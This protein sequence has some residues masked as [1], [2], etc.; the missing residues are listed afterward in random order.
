LLSGKLRIIGT[1]ILGYFTPK[2][3]EHI[4]DKVLRFLENL[5]II[6]F[7]KVNV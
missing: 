5:F 3:K 1:I 4:Q 2:S 6:G 7:K